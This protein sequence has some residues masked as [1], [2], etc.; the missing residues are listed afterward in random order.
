[1][2]QFNL[3]SKEG[4]V[5]TGI[6]CAIGGYLAY[7]LN[8]KFKKDA[9][10]LRAFRAEYVKKIDDLKIAEVMADAKDEIGKSAIALYPTIVD[11]IA[12]V[13]SAVTKKTIE[14]SYNKIEKIVNLIKTK[15][16]TLLAAEVA[17][18]E[19]EKERENKEREERLEKARLESLAAE[20]YS[21]LQSI[22]QGAYSLGRG[23]T[24]PFSTKGGKK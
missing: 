22:A 10:A 18:V 14:E 2:I 17:L 23:L 9:E 21:T 13:K 3:G 6:A 24:L 16:E 12:T 4:L 20:R 19:A 8:K 1:M 15:N 11:N 5:V 7:R